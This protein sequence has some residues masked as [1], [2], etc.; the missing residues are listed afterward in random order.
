MSGSGRQ[1]ETRG[2]VVGFR[3]EIGRAGAASRE[4]FFTWFDEAQDADAAFVRGA[5]DFS[6]HVAAPLA[7]HLAMPEAKTVLEIGH[8]GGR[9]LASAARHFSAAIGIDVHA[10]NDLVIGELQARGVRNV[11]LLQTDGRVIPIPDASVDAVFSFIVLLHVEKASIFATYLAESFRV[12]RRGGVAVV[13]FGRWCRLSHQTRSRVLYG[14]ERMI[15]RVLMPRGY[16][17]MSAPVNHVNLLVTLPYA[18]TTARR[19]GFRVAE[20]LVSRKRVPD[21]TALLGGQHG[22]VLRKP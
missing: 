17:E 4:E 1:V 2:H 18:V 11:R 8:G 22:L 12:L 19:V 15:E 6:I 9:L 3:E 16:R 21:G 5:W 14:A 20:R 13:Y 10:Q 7:R